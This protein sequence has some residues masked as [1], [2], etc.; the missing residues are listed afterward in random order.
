[1]RP[2]NFDINQLIEALRDTASV[3]DWHLPE[4]MEYEDLT[5]EDHAAIDAAIF[6]CNVCGWWY[7]IGELGDDSGHD[8]ICAGCC[9]DTTSEY[10]EDD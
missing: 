9:E 4:G 5:K 1:M 2:E 10:D 6:E 8:T 3:I 7:E